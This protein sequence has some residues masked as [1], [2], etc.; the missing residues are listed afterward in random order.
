MIVCSTHASAFSM[1]DRRHLPPF[2]HMVWLQTLGRP[3]SD[4][5]TTLC[6]VHRGPAQNKPGTGEVDRSAAQVKTPGL[7]CTEDMDARS[8]STRISWTFSLL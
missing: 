4:R 7:R 5:S 1:A 2:P 3:L 6:L 8:F